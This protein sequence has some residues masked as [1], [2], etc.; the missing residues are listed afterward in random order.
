MRRMRWFVP[1]AAAVGKPM[2][3]TFSGPP[4]SGL[5]FSARFLNLC[6]T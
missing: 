6:R 3:V 5:A 4:P 1:G 2:S